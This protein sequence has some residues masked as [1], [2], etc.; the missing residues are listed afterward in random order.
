MNKLST[1]PFLLSFAALSLFASVAWTNSSAP[2]RNKDKTTNSTSKTK[3]NTKD[4]ADMIFIPAGE[5]VMGSPQSE[6]DAVVKQ[7]NTDTFKTDT[8]KDVKDEGPQHKVFL[9]GYY[10][11]K[12]LVTVAQYLKFCAETGYKKPDAPDFNPN[13]SKRDHP[14]VNVSYND[15][16][17]YCKWAGARL[18]TEAEWEKA[19]SWDE[20]TKQ[21]HTFPWGDEFDPSKLWCSTAK[22]GDAG[23]TKAVG[24][25]PLGASS[26]GVLDMAGNVFQWCSDWYD[27]DFYGSRLATDRNAENQSVGEKKSRVLRGGSWFSDGAF[28]FRSSYRYRIEPVRR[29]R[30]GGFRCASGL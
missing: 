20:A 26:Y 29:G 27:K 11:Y 23:G 8:F 9:D 22:S 30:I 15:A 18:P 6:R 14:I 7:Y 28:Y 12:N 19:A 10:I 3:K 25:F 4:N 5:F 17:E 2:P 1:A 13:W 16:Q 24:S 21:K